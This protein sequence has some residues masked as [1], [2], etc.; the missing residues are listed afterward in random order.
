M[1]DL[2]FRAI[3]VGFVDRLHEQIEAI[4]AAWQNRDL[5]ELASFAHWLRGAAG[6]VGFHEFTEPGHALMQ[7]AREGRTE[8]IEAHLVEIRSLALRIQVPVGTTS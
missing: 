5:D 4:D 3:V 6:T 7:S 2:E 1:D 8:S